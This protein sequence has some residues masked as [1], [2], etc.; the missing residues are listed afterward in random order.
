M[1][2]VLISKLDDLATD[3]RTTATSGVNAIHTH[4]VDL[5][6]MDPTAD[7]GVFVKAIIGNPKDAPKSL[8][9]LWTGRPGQAKKKRKE[10]DSFWSDGEKER[11]ERETEK[12]LGSRYDGRRHD[13][14]RDKSDSSDDEESGRAWSGRMQRKI[15][16]WAAWVF[17]SSFLTQRLMQVL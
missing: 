7:L 1:H 13:R 5:A 4:G 15:E 17:L 2:R 11:E 8:R 6:S 3:L 10:K 12:E 14:E 16:H 9:Y